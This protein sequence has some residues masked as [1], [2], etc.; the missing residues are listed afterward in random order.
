MALGAAVS[1]Q[2]MS[3][4]EQAIARM[5]LDVTGL[6]DV[7]V[8]DLVP[9]TPLFAGGLGLDSIDALDIGRALHQRFGVSLAGDG[10]EVRADFTSIRSLARLVD[11]RGT[12]P[13]RP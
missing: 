4:I 7:R 8:E 5:I 10:A 9:D 3:P 13:G 6:E 1:E 12:A 2:A 11:T